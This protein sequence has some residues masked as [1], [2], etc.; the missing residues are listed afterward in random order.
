MVTSEALSLDEA[1][2]KARIEAEEHK[3]QVWAATMNIIDSVRPL[4]RPPETAAEE[5][6][7]Y[8]PGLAESRGESVSPA[9][10]RRAADYLDALA[11]AMECLQ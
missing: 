1:V 9:R 2:E 8:D 11:D 5:I 4:D 3:Q 10:L 7:L 6:S